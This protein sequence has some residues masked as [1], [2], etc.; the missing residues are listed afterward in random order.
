MPE[1]YVLKGTRTVHRRGEM[2]NH[3]FLFNPKE[4]HT[5]L[6]EEYTIISNGINGVGCTKEIFALALIHL[7]MISYLNKSKDFLI[8][9]LLKDF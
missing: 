1:P 6:R 3:L 7:I 4:V 5:M 8:I 2:S 9:I